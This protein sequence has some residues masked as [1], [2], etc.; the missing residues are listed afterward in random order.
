MNL[1]DTNP[2]QRAAVTAVEGPVLVLAG[3]GSGKTRVL[4]YRIAWM[5]EQKVCKPWQILALTFTNKAAGEMRERVHELLPGL[6]EHM[7]IGTFHSVFAQI[8]RREIEILGYGSNFVI[9]DA[10]DQLRLVKSIMTREGIDAKEL[11][12]K[13]VRARIS[14]AKNRLQDPEKFAEK[15]HGYHDELIQKIYAFYEAAL[16]QNNALDFDDL[17]IKPLELFQ[18]APE[19]LEFYQSRFRYI[20][21]D[22]YQDTNR[23]QYQ[24]I[25]QLAARYRNLCVVGD[26]DQSIYGWRGADIRNILDFTR[27][28][29]EAQVFK[30]EQNYRST[31]NILKVAHAV[32]S[33]IPDRHEKELWTDNAA[34]ERV[35][36]LVGANA[37]DEARLVV[38]RLEQLQ[39]RQVEL[40]NMA[41]LYRTNYQS[42]VLEDA[43]RR[44]GIPYT[45]VGGVRFYERREI[46]DVLAYLKLL[47]NPRDDVAFQRAVN[48]PRRG[49]GD[50]A[51]EALSALAR[52]R[53][54][55]LLTCARSGKGAGVT[56]GRAARGLA[57]FLEVITELEKGVEEAAPADVLQ[58]LVDLLDLEEVL[59]SEG[60]D[61]ESRWENVQEL[62][63]A[64]EEFYRDH[65]GGLRDFLEQSA[66]VSD[67]DTLDESS[68][69]VVLMTV[70]SA[71]GLEFDA[72][73]VTG[74]EEGLFPLQRAVDEG[75]EH[76]ERRLFYVAVTRARR[77]LF[78]LRAESRRFH[79]TEESS[80]LRELPADAIQRKNKVQP[81][82]DPFSRGYQGTFG[83]GSSQHSEPFPVAD[84]NQE[85]ERLRV[86]VTVSHPTFGLGRVI[87][88]NGRGGR[89]KIK[90]DFGDSIRQLVAQMA[91]L[92]IVEE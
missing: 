66:L 56:K 71:K 74:L 35:E 52:E 63:T 84:E 21:I 1:N 23:V 7:W 86:G 59:L 88:I 51:L 11:N 58:E 87:Q 57:S 89:A 91:K 82:R 20:L 24:V 32:V 46:K 4:T 9:Y 55:S 81:E 42:R 26:D 61:G 50:K 13:L 10:D 34:G 14:A 77:H 3:A 68:E 19:R 80:F 70:H 8:L 73:F 62:K 41:V 90:V 29:P 31:G 75:M 47:V 27:D 17:L 12:P 79:F 76:E 38:S 67:V 33:A 78:L 85:L 49:F 39:R 60:P 83:F 30:L 28:Y 18:K 6:E 69:Q 25:K 15:H 5:L 37:Q 44:R 92:S 40:S 53:G 36:L 64:M 2:Q 22:E 43:L 54:E 16:K 65:G 45:I 72:V 48:Y